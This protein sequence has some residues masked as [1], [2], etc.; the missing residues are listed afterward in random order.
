M[1]NETQQNELKTRWDRQDE[2][3]R[4]IVERENG[5][6]KYGLLNAF[7]N[8]A[9]ETELAQMSAWKEEDKALMAQWE[10]ENLTEA[11]NA[12]AANLTVQQWETLREHGMARKVEV[13]VDASES[14]F[15]AISEWQRV[16]REDALLSA[17]GP[18]EAL[19]AL[20]L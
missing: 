8:V 20:G 5:N 19:A 6:T 15:M 14:D 16:E 13:I 17:E 2:Y 4:I 11:E 12:P 7:Y 10:A 3:A 1:L 18:E 9:S